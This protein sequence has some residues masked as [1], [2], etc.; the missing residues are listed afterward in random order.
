MDDKKRSLF[1][2]CTFALR[3]V[4]FGLLIV[5]VLIGV[6]LLVGMIPVNH[7]F[8]PAENG[9]T[10]FLDSSPVHVDLLLPVCTETIDWR[11]QFSGE[12]FP[13]LTGP[14]T[15]VAIGWGDKR[16]FIETPTWADLKGANVAR[17]LL[18]VSTACLH[19][20]FTHQD[21]FGKEVRSV[22]I[23]VAQYER[24]VSHVESSFRLDAN[25]KKLPIPDAAYGRQDAF[26]E[27]HGTYHCLNTCNSWVGKAIRVAGVRTAWM[28]PLS[29]QVLFYCP[30]HSLDS[31][32]GHSE[33]G[34]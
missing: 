19:V 23:S 26:F 11:A 29:Q 21:H 9:V 5:P 25:G 7:D 27:A 17:A 22:T 16:F 32:S 4:L 6:I 12:C 30:D 3:I 33:E 14:M 28:T 8:S 18:G 34:N 10:I 24:L 15:H 1:R 20:S 13:D 31:G 2:R